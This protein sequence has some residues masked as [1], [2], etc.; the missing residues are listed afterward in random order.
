MLSLNIGPI[1][2][3][4][5]LAIIYLGL[6]CAW[7]VCWWLGRKQQAGA[8]NALFNLLLVWLLAARIS[9]V[10]LYLPSFR[11]N[12]LAIIDIRD[13][14]FLHIPGVIAALLLAAYYL[15]RQ[16]KL[17][18]PLSL[19]VVSGAL[20]SGFG[21]ALLYAFI[22]SQ[23]LPELQLQDLQGNQ[24]QLQQY[25]GKPLVINLWAT[26][27]PPCRREMPT[28]QQAQQQQ[29]EIN[30][31][32]INQ[33]ESSQHVQNFLQQQ[34]IKLENNLL[35]GAGK[36]GQAT[37]SLTLP[38][39]LFYDANGQLVKTHLGELSSASLQHALKT[40]STSNQKD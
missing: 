33:G 27:C 21:F 36:M 37:G 38:T 28:F 35:D 15:W 9:F 7:L 32:F 25:K 30:F 31:V 6:G 8:E 11:N 17:R 34:G 2:V 13:G 3:P 14:G 5:Y 24:L 26:W 1:S 19:A 40:I 16:P 20:V 22:S 12:W 23:Q 29:P 39:T 10:L 18:R 4:S